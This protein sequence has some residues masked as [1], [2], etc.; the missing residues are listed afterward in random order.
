MSHKE[1]RGIFPYLVTPTDKSGKLKEDVLSDLVNYLIEK[2]VH[3]LTPLGSTGEGAYFPWEQ[4]K[5][6]LEELAEEPNILYL[7][8]ASGNTGKLL[9]IFN[10]VQDRI[11]IFSASAHAPLFVFMMGGVGWMSGPA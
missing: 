6:M 9:S 1:F 7:K 11:K 10:A 5:R 8:D 2:G 4:K 3:G